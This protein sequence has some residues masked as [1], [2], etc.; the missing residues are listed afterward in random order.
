MSCAVTAQ[1]ICAFVFAHA[2]C[3]FSHVHAHMKYWSKYFVLWFSIPVNNFSGQSTCF[4]GFN[5]FMGVI[6]L[7]HE[8]NLPGPNSQEST[9]VQYGH[10]V[11]DRQPS[12]QT[13]T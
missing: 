10:R 1:L 13:L 7:A 12:W 6:C 5:Q 4:L 3:W 11:E 8:H 2:N 9:A